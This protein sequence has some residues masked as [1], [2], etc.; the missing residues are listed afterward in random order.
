MIDNSRNKAQKSVY[1]AAD[2]IKYIFKNI[3]INIYRC[4]GINRLYIEGKE[5]N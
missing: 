5:E 3:H 2:S 1:Y 4:L